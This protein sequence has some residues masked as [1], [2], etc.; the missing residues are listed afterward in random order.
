VH[1]LLKIEDRIILLLQKHDETSK[2]A[3]EKKER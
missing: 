1:P 3:V 2:P